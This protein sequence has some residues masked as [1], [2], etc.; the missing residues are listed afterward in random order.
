MQD[1]RLKLSDLRERFESHTEWHCFRVKETGKVFA[2]PKDYKAIPSHLEKIGVANNC[3]H[4]TAVKAA[5][6]AR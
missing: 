1:D 3:C 2:R 5:K 6:K 4:R